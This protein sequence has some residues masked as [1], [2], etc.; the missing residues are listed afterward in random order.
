M[1]TLGKDIDN[2]NAEQD[3]SQSNHRGG[4]KMLFK[5][6]PTNSGDKHNTYT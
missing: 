3:K 5:H 6:H 2:H 4:I 1:G